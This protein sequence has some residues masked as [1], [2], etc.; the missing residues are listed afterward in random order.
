MLFDGLAQFVQSPRVVLV[1]PFVLRVLPLC[2]R[3]IPGVL[4]CLKRGIVFLIRRFRVRDRSA[5]IVSV[6]LIEELLLR[7]LGL[8]FNWGPLAHPCGPFF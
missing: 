4:G 1:T 2:G 7:A 6:I 5:R 8:T 3:L